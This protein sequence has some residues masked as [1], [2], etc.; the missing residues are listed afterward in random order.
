[1]AARGRRLKKAGW[2]VVLT[3]LLSWGGILDAGAENKI[4]RL[5]APV[6]LTGPAAPW[7]L[8]VKCNMESF[9]RFINDRG[10]ITVKGQKYLID[11]FFAD[12][13]YTVAGGRAAAEKLIY[14]DKVD[15][16]VGSF[17]AEAISGWASL[18]TKEKK[19]AVIGGPVWVPKT[20]WPYLFRVSAS[21]DERSEALY[22]LM[23]EK[24]NSRSVLYVLADDMDGKQ[25]RENAIKQAKQKGIEIKEF[26]MVP[27]RTTDFYPFLSNA[28]KSNPDFVYC[29]LPPGS[30]AL[31]VKQSRELGYKGHI[32]NPSSMPGDLGKWQSIAGVEASKGYIGIM[33]SPEESSPLGV[34]NEKYF[35]THCPSF[36]STD[37]AYSIGPHILLQAI[38]KAQ[39]LDPDEILKVLRATEFMSFHKMSVRAAGEKTYGIKNHMTIPV[40][41][42]MITG[43]DKIQYLGSYKEMT[44]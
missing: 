28:L 16:L 21:N 26:V 24:F 1:M 38:E 36:E 31:V 7:G 18:S 19:L 10:G 29:K 41:F 11:T 43:K 37:L 12:D 39:S 13:K 15:F 5:G 30:V 8:S 44:P 2:L 42:S 34:E 23:K 9:K 25:V 4:L 17:G 27:P 20:E 6:P 32:A 3:F 33:V 35:K 40:S 14:T 22:S